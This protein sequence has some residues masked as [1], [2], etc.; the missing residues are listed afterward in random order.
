[1]TTFRLP[2]AKTL[3]TD[4]VDALCRELTDLTGLVFIVWDT[5]GRF[6]MPV[7]F[8]STLTGLIGGSPNLREQVAP[9]VKE[10]FQASETSVSALHDGLPC[11]HIP[12][13]RRSRTVFV[14]T[15]A[16][17]ADAQKSEA[18]SAWLTAQSGVSAPEVAQ[19]LAGEA[20]LPE[21]ALTPLARLIERLAA[22]Y[23]QRLDS[24]EQVNDVSRKLAEGYEEI[25]LYQR[26]ASKIRVSQPSDAFFTATCSELLEFLDVEAIVALYCEK[27]NRTDPRIVSLGAVPLDDAQ[28]LRL[29]HH[30]ERELAD[31][32]E[33]VIANECQD[34]AD[35]KAL[36]PGV[37]NMILV[38]LRQG[39]KLYGVIAAFNKNDDVEFYS[40]DVKLVSSVSGTIAVFV[41]NTHLYDDLQQL[42][43]GTVKA[44][45]SSI[46]AKD[47]YTCGHSERVAA[48][49]RRLGQQMGLPRE[50]VDRI[51]LA[52]LLH[53][54]G[55]IGVPE[56]I[57]LKNGRLDPAEFDTM[58]THPTIGARILAGVRELSGVIPGVLY[59]HERL[60]GRGYP[61]GLAPEAVPLDS[62]IIG[63][64]DA[65]D[66]MTSNRVYRPALPLEQVEMEIRRNTGTQFDV[67]CVD[68]LMELGVAE[69]IEQMPR[70]NR[71]VALEATLRRV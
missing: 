59:H 68:A 41:E 4:R 7:G 8:C 23:V 20:P 64:A 55:K 18:V 60:D 6:W 50:D 15:A 1:V 34:S 47:P 17:L 49:S 5:D 32:R 33:A 40:T 16:V 71:D 70:Q 48:L 54:I 45:V 67:R 26:M 46:D 44:L 19:R 43:L 14:F 36:V 63:L 9:M 39:K 37:S 69:V 22:E 61:K 57:L 12:V 65:F 10:V 29:Y 3:A 58:K 53:D 30:F 21:N 28:L 27:D 38:P 51:Y 62:R 24:E 2:E 11:L 13:R 66:A 56:V 35:L 52:G 25:T 31:G 42:M